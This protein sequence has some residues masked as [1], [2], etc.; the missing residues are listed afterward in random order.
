L[1]IDQDQEVPIPAPVPRHHT[2]TKTSANGHASKQ[3]SSTPIDTGSPRKICQLDGIA[4]DGDYQHFNTTFGLGTGSVDKSAAAEDTTVSDATTKV[5]NVAIE[6]DVKREEMNEEDTKITTF[7]YAEKEDAS[8]ED[9]KNNTVRYTKE[10]NVGDVTRE[11]THSVK[12]EDVSHVAGEPASPIKEEDVSH[13]SSEPTPSP[14]KEDVS[15][16]GREPISSAKK[17]DVSPVAR[18]PTPSIKEEDTSPVDRE[19]APTA[20]EEDIVM[21]EAE[22]RAL[23]KT[24]TGSNTT[25]V[26]LGTKVEEAEVKDSTLSLEEQNKCLDG[27]LDT[28][29]QQNTGQNTKPEN[30]LNVLEQDISNQASTTLLP[31]KDEHPEDLKDIA[32][33]TTDQKT[34]EDATVKDSKVKAEITDPAMKVEISEEVKLE[35]AAFSH[36]QQTSDDSAITESLAKQEDVEEPLSDLH[37]PIANMD[38][39]VQQDSL[40]VETDAQ[41]LQTVSS[42]MAPLSEGNELYE[43]AKLLGSIIAPEEDAHGSSITQLVTKQQDETIQE[44]TPMSEESTQPPQTAFSKPDPPP[45]EQDVIDQTKSLN[46]AAA[47]ESDTRE[48]SAHHDLVTK[49]GK[50]T[51]EGAMTMEEYAQP[52]QTAMLEEYNQ[53]ES[54]GSTS[55]LEGGH[56]IQSGHEAIAEQGEN[57]REDFLMVEAAQASEGVADPSQILEGHPVFDQSEPVGSAGTSADDIRESP[58][59]DNF[60]AETYEVVQEDTAM[61]FEE[62]AQ[63]LLSTTSDP[64]QI[65]EDHTVVGGCEPNGI[66]AAPAEDAQDA[67]IHNS[68]ADI[69]EIVKDDASMTDEEYAQPLQNAVSDPSQMLEDHTVVGGWEPNG[70]AITIGEV[71]EEGNIPNPSADLCQAVQEDVSMEE[72]AYALLDAS[73]NSNRILDDHVLVDLCDLNG[74]TAAIAEHAQEDTLM[75]GTTHTLKDT[76][77]EPGVHIEDL[78]MSEPNTEIEELNITT[79]EQESDHNAAD[80]ENDGFAIVT[81]PKAEKKIS[82]SSKGGATEP[83]KPRGPSEDLIKAYDNLFLTYYSR[84]PVINCADIEIALEQI[85]SLVVVA[86]T[87]DSLAIVRPHINSCILAFGRELY[88]AIARDPPRWIRLSILIDLSVVFKEG[89]VHIVGNYPAWNSRSTCHEELGAKTISLIQKKAAEL[90]SLLSETNS[91]LLMTSVRIDGKEIQLRSCDEGTH[92]TWLI[93]KIWWDWCKHALSKALND[94]NQNQT[95]STLVQLYH[96]L[97]QGGDAYLPLEEV[98]ELYA[99]LCPTEHYNGM[100]VKEVARDLNL[101]KNFA[102]ELAMPLCANNTMLDIG[103]AKIGYFTCTKVDDQE[104]PRLKVRF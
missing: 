98:L 82:S 84:S 80:L 44:D 57:T 62:A 88:Q 10:P 100:D 63:S 79:G 65:L 47:S 48:A 85:E 87:Y 93:L 38:E 19:S 40:A 54:E 81:T 75:E 74:A 73:S 59:L 53:S 26:E 46:I 43:Q 7:H 5:K 33:A 99:A 76:I 68:D 90:E 92:S 61:G 101:I 66:A 56:E 95:K 13:I 94:K 16:V 21:I 27:L 12:E 17:E 67:T 30:V 18:E 4:D 29:M 2:S 64:S 69:Y 41:S 83:E 96:D 77:S 37:S 15:P 91:T 39:P 55:P 6:R 14:R 52:S 24:E 25:Q 89:I 22:G 42:K 58:I 35:N 51:Q 86:G 31:V 36:V 60:D 45:E 9:T 34:L 102:Q 103:Q 71:A 49:D 1:I 78:R 11:S 97:A 20:K 23:A 50:T 8:N 32:T 3:P 28:P 70:T 104:M 72:A